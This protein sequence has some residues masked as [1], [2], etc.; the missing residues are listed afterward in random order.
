MEYPVPLP[1]LPYI[2]NAT[3]DAFLYKYTNPLNIISIYLLHSCTKKKGNKQ[4]LFWMQQVLAYFGTKP[5]VTLLYQRFKY[6]T[7]SAKFLP[8]PGTHHYQL[9]PMKFYKLNFVEIIQELLS[10]QD[11]PLW[12]SIILFLSYT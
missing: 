5:S 12:Q 8:Y 7:T 6:W 3:E 4:L 2:D 11:E 10:T 1:T 9:L